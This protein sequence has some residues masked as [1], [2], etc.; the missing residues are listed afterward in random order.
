MVTELSPTSI[1]AAATLMIFSRT[2]M[3]A[4]AAEPPPTIVD[5]PEEFP[6]P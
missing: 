3:A 6:N 5:R 2:S 4:F 1:R